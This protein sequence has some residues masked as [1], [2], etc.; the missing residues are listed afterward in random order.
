MLLGFL[1]T[2]FF[3]YSRGV[4]LPS[5]AESLADGSRMQISLGFSWAA[6]VGAIV[7]PALGKY[8]DQGSPKRVI[9]LG[10][11]LISV[12]YFLLGAAQTL[13]H[14]YLVIGLGFGVGM[15]CMGALAWHRTV[16]FWFDH[17]RGRAIAFAV[18]G[19]SLAGMMMPP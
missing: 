5:L 12:S 19:A 1:G 2:G 10:I 4:F 16:I 7:S 13:W 11:T 17:W 8:M 14:F 6:I 18:M 9:L 15:S 3:S